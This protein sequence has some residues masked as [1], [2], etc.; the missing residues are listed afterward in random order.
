MDSV[1]SDVHNVSKY[2]YASELNSPTLVAFDAGRGPLSPACRQELGD[3]GWVGELDGEKGVYELS[4]ASRE[5]YELAAVRTPKTRSKR[6][7]RDGVGAVLSPKM[8][9]R[10]G[11]RDE[12]GAALSPRRRSRKTSWDELAAIGRPKM[13]NQ[14]TSGDDALSPKTRSRKGSRNE[15]GAVPTS[16]TRVQRMDKRMMW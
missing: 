15:L 10:K 9:S 13:R 16:K 2:P 6:V 3:E 1:I 4:R 7:S 8:G 12:V 5:I 11:R 14:R